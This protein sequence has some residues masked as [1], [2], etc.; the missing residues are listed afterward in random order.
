MTLHLFV[1]AI[2][3]DLAARKALSGFLADLGE[4]PAGTLESLASLRMR[5]KAAL[6]AKAW[7]ETPP[8]NRAEQDFPDDETTCGV[9]GHED[10]EHWNRC[11]DFDPIG[12]DP[13]I[14]DACGDPI[15]AH[16]PGPQS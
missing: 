15:V 8:C 5:Y 4:T 10:W 14:C 11:D 13:T 7:R 2:Y 9:C 12:A 16:P 3:R 6:V 1:R